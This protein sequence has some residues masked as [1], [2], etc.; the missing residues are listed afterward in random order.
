METLISFDNYNKVY[1]IIENM[2]KDYER[3]DFLLNKLDFCQE[4]ISDERIPY[5]PNIT[6]EHNNVVLDYT[7][8]EDA[9]CDHVAIIIRNAGLGFSDKVLSYIF[10]KKDEFKTSSL[11]SWDE[12]VDIINDFF[13]N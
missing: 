10:C 5:R 13:K 1:N 12:A 9:E 8:N 11:S 6:I 2:K 7:L 3:N 4:I